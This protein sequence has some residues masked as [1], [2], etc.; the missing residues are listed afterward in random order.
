MAVYEHGITVAD[1]ESDFPSAE[2]GPFGSQGEHG[3]TAPMVE[4]WITRYSA[5]ANT[6]LGARNGPSFDVS[7]DLGDNDAVDTKGA[8]ISAVVSRAL[9]KLRRYEAAAEHKADWDS[10][11]KQWSESQDDKETDGGSF[12]SRID[13]SEVSDLIWG[14]LHRW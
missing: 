14:K 2:P 1:I 7:S 13:T 6:L 3:V 8:I 5:R 11:Y 12:Y 9:Y 4:A 10:W